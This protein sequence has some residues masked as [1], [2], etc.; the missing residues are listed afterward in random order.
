MEIFCVKL[1]FTLMN[2]RNE[3]NMAF[4]TSV[5]DTTLNWTVWRSLHNIPYPWWQ[6]WQHASHAGV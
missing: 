5:T 4:H 3:H 6:Y 2:N 1:Y